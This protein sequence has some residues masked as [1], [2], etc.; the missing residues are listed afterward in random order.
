MYDA[1]RCIDCQKHSNEWTSDSFG[2]QFLPQP[3][4]PTANVR[5]QQTRDRLTKQSNSGRTQKRS[6]QSCAAVN[7]LKVVGKKLHIASEVSLPCRTRGGRLEAFDDALRAS[8]C[9]D[10]SDLLSTDQ[11]DSAAKCNSRLTTHFSTLAT[12]TGEHCRHTCYDSR[13]PGC[14]PETCIADQRLSVDDCH[15][16]CLPCPTCQQEAQ[17]LNE[18]DNTSECSE[19]DAAEPETSHNTAGTYRNARIDQNRLLK[20][21]CKFDT[22]RRRASAA[23]EACLLRF[24]MR[25]KQRLHLL[26]LDDSE[27]QQ[28]DSDEPPPMT[29]AA[30][31]LNEIQGRTVDVNLRDIID[32]CGPARS[33]NSVTTW[34]PLLDDATSTEPTDAVISSLMEQFEHVRL[35]SATARLENQKRFENKRK[36]RKYKM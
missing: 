27:N 23:R 14:G 24:E 33:H 3:F 13:S 10:Q 18:Q 20:L 32:L 9:T 16:V 31:T 29:T 35:N 21:L 8:P 7:S 30:A 22:I 2:L 12:N 34:P 6:L 5:R 28:K 4:C 26:D 25:Q 36:Q 11:Y 15:S 17:F 19:I 1:E